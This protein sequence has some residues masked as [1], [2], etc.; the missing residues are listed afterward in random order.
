MA[1]ETG[2]IIPLGHWILQEA[3]RQIKLWKQ[4]LSLN[5]LERLAINVSPLQ[6]SQPEFAESTLLMLRE[7]EVDPTGWSLS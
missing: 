2:L 3:C 1:E 7:M 4:D 5:S 6:F